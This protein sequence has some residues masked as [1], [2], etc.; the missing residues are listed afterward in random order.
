MRLVET[1]LADLDRL[2]IFRGPTD[3]CFP[4]VKMQGATGALYWLL[5][6]RL[7]S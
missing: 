6:E 1:K 7:A 3:G 2:D 5:F 4:M